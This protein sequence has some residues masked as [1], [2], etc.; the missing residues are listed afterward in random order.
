MKMKNTQRLPCHL[1]L[2]VTK[3]ATKREHSGE[4]CFKTT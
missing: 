3:Q 1:M 4:T 2:A